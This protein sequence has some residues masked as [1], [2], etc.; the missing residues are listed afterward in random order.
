[1]LR[2]YT[3]FRLQKTILNRNYTEGIIKGRRASRGHIVG[4]GST[5][6]SNCSNIEM[7]EE[8][9]DSPDKS[10]PLHTMRK[11]IDKVFLSKAP[12]LR[13]LDTSVAFRKLV[14]NEKLKY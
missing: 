2:Y 11:S 1:M 8:I 9:I 12:K 5:S 7:Q 3:R 13:T 4:G 10:R 6:G 14:I